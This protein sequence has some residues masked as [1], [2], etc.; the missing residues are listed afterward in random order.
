V[1][2]WS[3]ADDGG[4][5]VLDSGSSIIDQAGLCSGTTYLEG[6]SLAPLTTDTNRSY[7]RSDGSS[8]GSCFDE[9]NNAVDFR[10]ISPSD[11]QNSS[12]Q[13]VPCLVVTNVTASASTPDGTYVTGN[14]VD[15]E[16]EFSSL[17]NVTGTPTL[18]LETGVTDRSAT[19]QSG[20]GTDTLVFRYSVQSGDASGDLDYVSNSS[21]SASGGSITGA[22]GNA[23]LSLPQPGAAGSLG[24]NRN[25]IIDNGVAPSVL[26]IKRQDPSASITNSDTL[27]FRVAFSE[28]VSNVDTGDFAATGTSGSP[29]LLTQVDATTYDVEVSGGDLAGYNGTVGL[30]L[31]GGQNIIDTMGTALPTVEPSTDQTY[32]MDNILPSVTI[33]QAASQSDPASTV[34][35]NFTVVFSETISTSSFVVGDVTQN[36]TANFITWSITNSGDNKTF[37]LS[38]TGVG[39]NGT[40]IPFISAG[41]VNDVAGNTNTAST[42]TDGSVLFND[43]VPPTVT[44]NQASGQADPTTT[45]PIKFTIVFS[46]PILTSIFTTSDITQN[47]TASGITWSIT[48]SGDNKTFTLS[49]TA[50]T[51]RGTL[52]PS[53]AANR[54][55]DLVGNNNLAST[56]TD[57]SVNY[58]FPPPTPTKTL[59]ATSTPKP[60]ATAVIPPLVAINEFVP[61]AGHDWN[62]DGLINTGD[63]YIELINHGTVDVNLSGYELDDE[64]NIGSSPY[65]ITETIILKPGERVVF[66]GSKTKLVLNDGGDGVRLNKPNGQLMDAYN[67][68]IVNYPD[69]SFCRLPD[70]GGADDWSI[71]CYPTPGLKNTPSGSILRPPTQLN[72]DEALCPISDNGPEAFAIAECE[73]FGNKIWNRFYWDRFGWFDEMILPHIDSK[74]EVFAQ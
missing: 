56:S 2:N 5:A 19:Y 35:V 36:G 71:H 42:G 63:E 37:T 41:N 72:E 61:R 12:D 17:V 51:N 60:A 57:N 73:P 66:Y 64:V 9:N 48:N 58:K 11:P 74:W 47:G 70:D 31:S 22:V 59:K 28:P 43:T 13:P 24:A 1:S 26:S 40:I 55:T 20:S 52:I 7:L 10:L 21:L 27:T 69:Q 46:E 50:V 44:I 62:N 45:L 8:A 34:P 4:F 25:I 49:A 15:I 23:V 16:V 14:T 29:T 32:E 18:V 68:S 65:K 30:D 39:Q 54:V 38:A 33:D 53:I 67:Y 3:V 6:T